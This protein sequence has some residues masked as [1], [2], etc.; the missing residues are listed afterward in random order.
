MASLGNGYVYHTNQDTFQ[1]LWNVRG[2]LLIYGR[3][4]LAQFRSMALYIQEQEVALAAV[5]L[6]GGEDGYNHDK[7]E[8]DDH[9]ADEDEHRG[10][11]VA[12]G[13]GRALFAEVDMSEEDVVENGTTAASRTARFENFLH[14][15]AIYYDDRH[16]S[17]VWGWVL[18][19]II[20]Q[21]SLAV[22]LARKFSN[23]G[24]KT[25]TQSEHA[26][27]TTFAVVEVAF[28]FLESI[29]TRAAGL[30]LRLVLLLLFGALFPV[31]TL[32]FWGYTHSYFAQ[33]LLLMLLYVLPIC[34]FADVVF[35]MR[36]AG[37]SCGSTS[38]KASSQ[39][40]LGPQQDG[41]SLAQEDQ[42]H[43]SADHV[44]ENNN[45]STTS[46]NSNIAPLLR[47][48]EDYGA[49]GFVLGSAFLLRSFTALSIIWQ[50]WIVSLSTR[51]LVQVVVSAFDKDLHDHESSV[52][53]T[54][55]NRET[56]PPGI[57][58]AGPRAIRAF[59]APYVSLW[60]AVIT[61]PAWILTAQPL[62]GSGIDIFVPLLRRSSNKAPPGAIL[63]AML[64]LPVFVAFA[65]LGVRVSSAEPRFNIAAPSVDED[66]GDGPEPDRTEAMKAIKSSRAR[67]RSTKRTRSMSRSTSGVA[68]K[69][70]KMRESSAKKSFRGSSGRAGTRVDLSL[71]GYVKTTLVDA[72]SPLWW[73]LFRV[74]CLLW[75]PLVLLQ[76]PAG[77]FPGFTQDKPKVVYAHHLEHRFCDAA[78]V[79]YD[80]RDGLWFAALDFLG[81]DFP[82]TGFAGA[83]RTDLAKRL[84]FDALVTNISGASATTRDEGAAGGGSDE[85]VKDVASSGPRADASM[86]QKILHEPKPI[87][88]PLPFALPLRKV[89]EDA[90]TR[91]LP[92][93]DPS[94]R[95]TKEEKIGTTTRRTSNGNPETAKTTSRKRSSEEQEEHQLLQEERSLWMKVRPLEF[96]VRHEWVEY[97]DNRT[98][99]A[100]APQELHFEDA[101]QEISFYRTWPR[102]AASFTTSSSS[103]GGEY[104]KNGDHMHVEEE[105]KNS[106]TTSTS[107]SSSTEKEN[108]KKTLRTHVS[109][110]CDQGAQAKLVLPAAEVVDWSFA[111][112]QVIAGSVSETSGRRLPPPRNDCDCHWIQLQSVH[113]NGTWSFSFDGAV[114]RFELLCERPDFLTESLQEQVWKRHPPWVSITYLAME[115]VYVWNRVDVAAP[116][117]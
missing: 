68:T 57:K 32:D 85:R 18:T 39:D 38:W 35:R 67:S 49:L 89:V 82:G 54:A 28:P 69:H 42:D 15:F 94:S 29:A 114:D 16:S 44:E 37:A 116:E 26:T 48:K 33:P 36:S 99:D 24:K 19:V 83:A 27:T 75:V 2:D 95:F 108:A 45:T 47:A 21:C 111:H 7:P 77:I 65:F 41:R 109:L 1:H 52:S 64:A 93:P 96:K 76:A 84:T 62:L 12:S 115:S 98:E 104:Y 25:E 23:K 46:E 63:G 43:L 101:S 13:P 10:R 105:M 3:N 8:H 22:Q 30:V 71:L 50:S 113:R 100:D 66:D 107:T 110:T 20:L 40:G 61:L 34:L 4:V 17:Q 88:G 87:Y 92:L 11:K 73:F 80:R 106:T 91:F 97:N 9:H 31:I 60:K 51:A 102:S 81:L 117:S 55:K 56:R 90:K 14:L 72:A 103:R 6:S 74:Y 79:C 5:P 78:Q 112:D 58:N 59:I 70:E 86:N 53:G